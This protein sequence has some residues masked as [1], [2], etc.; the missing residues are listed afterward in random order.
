MRTEKKQSKNL[1]AQLLILKRYIKEKLKCNC[2]KKKFWLN[3]NF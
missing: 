3:K 2:L 1:S